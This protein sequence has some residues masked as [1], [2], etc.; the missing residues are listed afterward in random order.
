MVTKFRGSLSSF[1]KYVR[2]R[3]IF[4]SGE[5]HACYTHTHHSEAHSQSWALHVC[6]G[7]CKTSVGVPAVSC[8]SWQ[9]CITPGLWVFTA[10]KP[11]FVVDSCRLQRI[12]MDYSYGIRKGNWALKREGCG[13][14]SAGKHTTG[15]C[16][17]PNKFQGETG[18][19]PDLPDFLQNL[20]SGSCILSTGL[21]ALFSNTMSY[22][23]GIRTSLQSRA[24]H[25]DDA[26][27]CRWHSRERK[28]FTGE[29][30]VV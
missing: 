5:V 29:L 30:L 9:R 22:P 27:C 1:L 15:H 16:Q 17:I 4:C 11:A 14:D 10:L 24:K 12:I 19:F 7:Y 8:I 21:I 3:L 23:A 6:T 13:S 2:W 26:V 25:L 28:A 20:S 18:W